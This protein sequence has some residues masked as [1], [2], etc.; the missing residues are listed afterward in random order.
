MR[1]SREEKFM[2]PVERQTGREREDRERE[3][4]RL[5]EGGAE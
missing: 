2:G 1:K 4:R 5:R 3:G